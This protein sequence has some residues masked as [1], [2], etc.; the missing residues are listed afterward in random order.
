MT[1]HARSLFSHWLSSNTA[2]LIP[3]IPKLGLHVNINKTEWDRQLID[4]LWKQYKEN[5]NIL[6][7]A[8]GCSQFVFHVICFHAYLTFWGI[9]DLCNLSHSL[10][11]ILKLE[12]QSSKLTT[13]SIQSLMSS[14][15][16]SCLY[17]EWVIHRAI[18]NV[19]VQYFSAIWW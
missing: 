10:V 2:I 3:Q 13:D 7:K 17:T 12:P 18:F 4:T 16:L 11:H 15:V 8:R 9:G 6:K 19:S 5:V 1:E 14:I